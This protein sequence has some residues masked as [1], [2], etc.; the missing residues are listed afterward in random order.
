MLNDLLEMIVK[1]NHHDIVFIYVYDDVFELCFID[2]DTT[3]GEFRDYV[4]PIA[5][6]NLHA[7]IKDNCISK[8]R[9][10]FGQPIYYFDNF[11]LLLSYN[12][13]DAL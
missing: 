5:T 1:C 3:E 4:D 11:C 9:N 6:A 13:E 7:W 2:W 10:V 8:E 12:S